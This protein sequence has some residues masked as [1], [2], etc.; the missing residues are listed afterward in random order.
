M[1]ETNLYLIGYILQIEA[2]GVRP[3]RGNKNL[4]MTRFDFTIREIFLFSKR[5]L[6]LTTYFETNGKVSN[7]FLDTLV[8]REG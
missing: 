2:L 4:Q 7:S 3:T 8:T 6:E 1:S 5:G